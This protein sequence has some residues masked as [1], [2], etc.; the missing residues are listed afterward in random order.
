[1]HLVSCHQMHLWMIVVFPNFL[2][3]G[4]SC[5]ASSMWIRAEIW[6]SGEH[7]C[8]LL[9]CAKW[10]SYRCRAW[11]V[12]QEQVRLILHGIPVKKEVL[13]SRTELAAIHLPNWMAWDR[14]S[15]GCGNHDVSR[16]WSQA[17][18]SLLSSTQSPLA[19]RNKYDF[20][21]SQSPMACAH[22]KALLA[23][24]QTFSDA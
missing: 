12:S 17:A 19:H 5:S 2:F 3:S 1:M 7:R 18:R 10:L 9:G 8:K 22:A 16:R 11:S 24:L 13:P 23:S 4:I 21:H 20:A 6:L 14:S 15:E